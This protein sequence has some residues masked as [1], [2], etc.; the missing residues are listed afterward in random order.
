MG[1]RDDHSLSARDRLLDS[2]TR[3]FAEL[4]YDETSTQMIADAAGL[5]VDMATGLVGRKRDLYLAVMERAY[6]AEQAML[7]TAAG[8]FTQD[9]PGMYRFLDRYIDFFVANPQIAALWIHRRLSDA[10]DISEPEGLYS[11]PQVTLVGDA[12]RDMFAP[13]VDV[14]FFLWTIVWNV[15]S[16]VQ[17]GVPDA[18]GRRRGPQ[19]HETLLRFRAHMREMVRRMLPPDL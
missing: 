3:L 6:Q 12:L 9:G 5:D 19:D 4:G 10:T 15:H 13:G 16:F 7:E 2:A 1:M 17:G 8:E 18:A 11:F 14:E